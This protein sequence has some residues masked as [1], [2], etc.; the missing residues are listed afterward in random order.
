MKVEE[1]TIGAV[2]YLVGTEAPLRKGKV[3]GVTSK[4][5]TAGDVVIVEWDSGSINK[6]A[7]DKLLTEEV[8]KALQDRLEEDAKKLEEEFEK[9]QKAC[10]DKLQ[11]AAELISEAAKLA[12]S[13]GQELMDMYDAVGPLERAMDHAGWS[14]SSW[15]C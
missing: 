1:C 3:A 5:P 4:H 12:Q 2:V 8:G 7:V 15:H 11:K 13:H 10:K 9:V 14:T 6:V